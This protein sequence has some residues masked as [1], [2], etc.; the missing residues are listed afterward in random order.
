MQGLPQ[1]MQRLLK[2]AREASSTPSSSSSSSATNSGSEE[3]LDELIPAPCNSK[4]G[5]S[6][7]SSPSRVSFSEATDGTAAV[8]RPNLDKSIV[9]IPNSTSMPSDSRLDPADP[10]VDPAAVLREPSS[11][12]SQQT[13]FPEL[14]HMGCSEGQSSSS[15]SSSWVPSW[16]SLTQAAN[17]STGQGGPP[18]PWWKLDSW[19]TGPA[20]GHFQRWAL[21][22][23]AIP[24][25][26]VWS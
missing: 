23:R 8:S 26:S 2:N 14:S 25:M 7:A 9:P 19:V 11:V 17:A 12:V 4:S 21:G 16:Y 3:E 22:H 6:L 13:A 18:Q 10:S 15:A 1:C 5:C 20:E 24:N